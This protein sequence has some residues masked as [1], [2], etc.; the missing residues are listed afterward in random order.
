MPSF[1]TQ[2][3]QDKWDNLVKQADESVKQIRTKG[4]K[5]E[6]LDLIATIMKQYGYDK[7]IEDFAR[8]ARRKAK[9]RTAGRKIRSRT[10]RDF[11]YTQELEKILFEE[12]EALA[13]LLESY[14]EDIL[15]QLDDIQDITEAVKDDTEEIL[16]I[17]R[18]DEEE[19]DNGPDGGPDD[20]PDDDDFQGSPTS[21][22]AKE[23]ESPEELISGLL[24]DVEESFEDALN[25]KFGGPGGD[26]FG[27]GFVDN[28]SNF[29][30][31]PQGVEHYANE[32]QDHNDALADVLDKLGDLDLSEDEK[33]KK[34]AAKASTWIRTLQASWL[35]K[36]LSGTFDKG[37]SLFQG[38]L[39]LFG[40]FLA[41]SLLSGKLFDALDRYL[42]LD[43]VA[44]YGAAYYNDL[45]TRT[46]DLVRYISEKLGIGKT[47]ETAKEW[48]SNTADA[49]SDTVSNAWE[50]TYGAV[51]GFFNKDSDSASPSQPSVATVPDSSPAYSPTMSQEPVPNVAPGT[52]STTSSTVNQGATYSGDS[53]VY[54]DQRNTRLSPS[55]GI[56]N[57]MTQGD[58]NVT[59]TPAAESGFIIPGLSSSDGV[60]RG[61]P[62][63]AEPTPS[64]VPSL[65]SIPTTSPDVGLGILNAGALVS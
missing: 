13:K 21:R 22:V 7:A 53:N 30:G 16:E 51:T 32:L 17:L 45:K 50:T 33:D 57:S 34:E 61:K 60:R 1:E 40:R 47:Y 42:D 10:D 54:T 6:D 63:S 24:G 52:V 8:D 28:V 18:D 62:V 25:R 35:G 29:V 19:D 3:E 48:I 59:S 15:K 26:F 9:T 14:F 64:M 44:E 2:Y 46:Q 11:I 43:R 55:F 37:A 49:I 65:S 4:G 20:G 38:L 56:D 27:S 36:K 41:N 12:R 58:I 5:K 23:G 39:N 31:N